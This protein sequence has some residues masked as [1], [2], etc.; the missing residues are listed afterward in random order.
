[1]ESFEELSKMPYL[2]IFVIIKQTNDIIIVPFGHPR[3]LWTEYSQLWSYSALGYYH[4][5]DHQCPSHS[6]SHRQ[7][8]L[9][10]IDWRRKGSSHSQGEILHSPIQDRLLQS[11]RNRNPGEVGC[12]QSDQALAAQL[13]QTQLSGFHR[14]R[15]QQ[16]P[17]NHGRR[18]NRWE[19]LHMVAQ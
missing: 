16:Q 13:Q 11:H 8:Q 4:C 18:Q 1:M 19:R 7:G 5:S 14:S 2:L 10:R 9:L 6:Q 3:D 15:V 17:H 12:L